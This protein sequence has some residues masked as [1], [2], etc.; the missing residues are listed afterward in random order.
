MIDFFVRLDKLNKQKTQNENQQLIIQSRPDSW[1]MFVHGKI[2]PNIR[3]AKLYPAYSKNDVWFKNLSKSCKNKGLWKASHLTWSS[4]PNCQHYPLLWH[5][6]NQRWKFTTMMTQGGYFDSWL[7]FRCF[8]K[9]LT[10]NQIFGHFLGLLSQNPVKIP[11]QINVDNE[12][13]I[14]W[15]EKTAIFA[16]GHLKPQAIS[17]IL[18]VHFN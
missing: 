17:A 16:E 9:A 6:E 7:L 2:R 15:F 13:K 10:L 18:T 11:A 5:W 12:K 1:P 3:L 4:Q 8:L 14:C